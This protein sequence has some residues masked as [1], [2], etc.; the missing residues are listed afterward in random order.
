[1]TLRVVTWPMGF[2]IV[3]KGAQRLFFLTEL[4]WTVVSLGLAW[5]LVQRFGHRG[6]G[7]AFFA[8]YVFHGLMLYPIVRSLTGF[9]WSDSTRR[10]GLVFLSSVAAVF[11]AFQTLPQAWAIGF[12]VL[13][14]LL[15][16]LYSIRT[17][18]GLLSPKRI[19]PAL[20]RLMPLLRL[21]HWIK[22]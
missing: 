10:T 1:M 4:A 18:L 8:S 19:P 22:P 6:A 2:I 12:G 7:M 21:V 14:T 3:A 17:L 20:Q 13:A 16:T 15:S 11:C 9:R 5:V